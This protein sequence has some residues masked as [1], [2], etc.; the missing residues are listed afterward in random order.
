MKDDGGKGAAQ[1]LNK[2]ITEIMEFLEDEGAR[3]E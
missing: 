1:S 3:P 2:T